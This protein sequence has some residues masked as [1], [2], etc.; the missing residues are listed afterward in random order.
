MSCCSLLSSLRGSLQPFSHGVDIDT[1]P[2]SSWQDYQRFPLL[3]SS[4]FRKPQTFCCEIEL[5]ANSSEFSP[6]DPVT[7]NGQSGG[8]RTNQQLAPSRT[9]ERHNEP[10]VEYRQRSDLPL[11][12]GKNSQTPSIDSKKQGDTKHEVR[13][14]EVEEKDS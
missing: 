14:T 10:T 3:Y 8:I 4:L 13:N 9:H 1:G 6:N 12:S 11:I 2:L 7:G 5:F